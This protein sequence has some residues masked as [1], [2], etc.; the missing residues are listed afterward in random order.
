MLRG[1]AHPHRRSPLLVRRR[2]RHAIVLGAAVAVGAVSGGCRSEPP[3]L[4]VGDLQFAERDL[5]GLGIDRRERLA[6]I[7]ALGLAV[8]RREVRERSTALQARATQRALVGA[9]R[10]RHLLATADVGDDVLVAQY[11]MDPAHELV[12]RHLVVLAER[13]MP[14]SLREEA[15]AR[16]EA[17]LARI[18][19]GED[20]TAVAG[21]VSE[22]PGAT[23][24]GGLLT[25]GREGT[26]V[27]EFWTAASALEPGQVSDVVETQFGFHVLRLE[28]RRVVPFA[29]MRVRTADRVAAMLQEG[30]FE[31]L[32]EGISGEISL[33]VSVLTGSRDLPMDAAL[34][35]WPQGSLNGADFALYVATEP[36]AVERAATGGGDALRD[37]V[38][39]AALEKALAN[40]ARALGLEPD[41]SVVDEQMD[42]WRLQAE[43]WA[44]V[45]GL[46]G[47]GSLDELGQRAFAAL[48]ST[49][50]N[51]TVARE[52]L[53]RLRGPLLRSLYPI[54]TAAAAG[55]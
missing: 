10:T 7:A 2:A 50:Q 20:F 5:L 28:E 41:D 36:A 4:I 48:G 29:E 47:A 15:R 54:E 37:L 40:R 52:E 27:D 26:W 9:L 11:E 34:A 3:G 46:V 45:L 1:P 25:P 44:A 21:E 31:E 33:D 42:D 35:T 19:S 12:V 8:N 16:T 23:E 14:R 39:Q 22:E 24:R 6:E 38:R 13:G 17:A 53:Q 55:S 51:A 43:G 18:R 32:R 30:P 49:G